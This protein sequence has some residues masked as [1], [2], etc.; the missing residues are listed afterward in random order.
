[1]AWFSFT[2]K[3]L[4]IQLH[5]VPNAKKSEIVGIHGAALK[6]KISSPPVDGKAN[7]EIIRFFS[8]LFGIPKNHVELLSGA[9][10][11]SKRILLHGVSQNL[12][13][14]D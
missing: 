3:G 1:M 11:K 2:E 13:Q 6:I 10:S 7:E 4:V 9:T 8:S 5:I 14:L 12:I